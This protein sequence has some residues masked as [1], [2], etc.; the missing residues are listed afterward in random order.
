MILLF[1]DTHLDDL[2]DNE[3]RW[4]CFEHVHRLIDQYDVSA[5]FNLGDAWDRK[6]RFTSAFVNRLVDEIENV[7]A[8]V[9]FTILKGNHDN[10]LRGPVFFDF[11]NGRLPGVRYVTKPQPCGDLLLLPFSPNPVAEWKDIDFV[12]YKAAFMHVTPTGSISENGFEL[13]GTR[14]PTVPKGLKLYTG[15][16]HVPQRIGQ[17][18]VVGC[19]HPIKFGD[20][21]QPRILLL[22][23]DTFEIVEEIPI[24]TIHK[25]VIEVNSIEALRRIDVEAGD[26]ARIRFSLPAS[27]IDR[28]GEIEAAILAWSR[29][30]RVEVVSTEA[31]LRVDRAVPG[32]VDTDASPEA[33]FRQFAGE[34]GIEGG[35]LDVGL[36][37][38]KEVS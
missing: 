21:F 12:K 22:D 28:W 1:T 37:L 17:F 15:D 16:V 18:T 2:P 29:D 31:D 19:P 13:P 5:V 20:R 10:P 35:L 4:G 27:D 34:E 26:K 23:E 14:L 9:P 30:N 24:G 33:V 36:E 38:L 11:V 32:E 6:D 3:Y 8:R 25:R 7:G